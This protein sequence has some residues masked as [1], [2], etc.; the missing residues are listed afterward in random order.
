M[1]KIIFSLLS[2]LSFA[3]FASHSLGGHTD[4]IQLGQYTYQVKVTLY[5]ENGSLPAPP[6][7]TYYLHKSNQGFYNLQ[8]TYTALQDTNFVYNNRLISVF[9]DTITLNSPGDYRVTWHECCRVSY[10]NMAGSNN[11]ALVFGT[12]FANYAVQGSTAYVPNSPP[13]FVNLV[14]GNLIAGSV[15]QFSVFAIDPDG[16]SISYEYADAK[17]LHLNSTF[18][19]VAPQ[20]SLTT[21]HSMQNGYYS[22]TNYGIVTWTPSTV[23]KFGNSIV[24]KEYRNGQVIG[25]NRIELTYNVTSGSTIPITNLVNLTPTQG[26]WQTYI[27]PPQSWTSSFDIPS[28][29]S[30]QLFG[31]EIKD[32]IS[33]TNNSGSITLSIDSTA[34]LE[35]G[36]YPVVV[37]VTNGVLVVDN[38]LFINVINNIGNIEEQLPVMFYPNPAVSQ[39]FVELDAELYSQFGLIKVLRSGW[40]DISE[41]SAGVYYIYTNQKIYPLVKTDK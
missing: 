4:V 18:V 14:P 23:G 6:Q 25:I 20:T 33:V 21:N 5:Q 17:D 36:I 35:P 37:R 15:N 7:V 29:C 16:D 9:V 19:P 28:N 24:V 34:T 31:N 40:N 1:K 2:L 22:V 39:L 13:V 32:L 26:V 3:A 38:L 41:V 11:S 30:V 10:T 27:Y 8:S 12:D